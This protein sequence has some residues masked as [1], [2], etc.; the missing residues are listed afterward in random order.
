MRARKNPASRIIALAVLLGAIFAVYVIRI[1]QFQLV[2]GEEYR[3][4]G[5]VRYTREVTVKAARGEIVDR[6]GIPIAANRT[7]YNVVFD[8]SYVKMAEANEIIL[9]AASV[10]EKQNEKINQSIPITDTE[11]YAFKDGYET[12]VGSLKARIG[13]QDYATFQ[14]VWDALCERY[15]VDNSYSLKEKRIIIGT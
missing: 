9:A 1:M 2:D 5:D 13:L 12:S 15:D 8:K 14:N 4:M 3:Q 11:P 10:V 7:A 6:N